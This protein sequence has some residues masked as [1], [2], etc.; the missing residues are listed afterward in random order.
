MLLILCIKKNQPR[1]RCTADLRIIVQA[2]AGFGTGGVAAVD[3]GTAPAAVDEG[4]GGV[5]A[6][7]EGSTAPAAVDEGTDVDDD[8]TCRLLRVF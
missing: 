1:A 5:A 4:T 2:F 6:V 7:D 3:E 8:R